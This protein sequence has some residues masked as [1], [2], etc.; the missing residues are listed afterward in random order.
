MSIY[1]IAGAIGARS[2]LLV[3]KLRSSR[4]PTVPF[5]QR[6]YLDVALLALGGGGE[7][8]LAG[9]GENPPDLVVRAYDT[10]T[11]GALTVHAGAGNAGAAVDWLTR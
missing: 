5:F 8:W 7:L 4:P 10:E 9:A 11:A 6:Y 2:G 1:V 3:H